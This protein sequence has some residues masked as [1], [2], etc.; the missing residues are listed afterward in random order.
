MLLSDNGGT[1]MEQ[2]DFYNLAITYTDKISAACNV[3]LYVLAVL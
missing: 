2:V 1:Y 3:F